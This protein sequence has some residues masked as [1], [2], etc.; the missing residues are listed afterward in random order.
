MYHFKCGWFRTSLFSNVICVFL[1][2]VFFFETSLAFSKDSVF[3]KQPDFSENYALPLGSKRD[4]IYQLNPNDFQKSVL[5]GKIHALRYPV[6]VTGLLMPKKF[7]VN[8]VNN[9][10]PG[11]G[12]AIVNPIFSLFSPWDSL[13]DIYSWLGLSRYPANSLNDLYAASDFASELASDFSSKKSTEMFLEASVQSPYYLPGRSRIDSDF[14]GA[15]EQVHHGE[16]TV[17]FSCGACHVGNLFGTPVI[18]LT[19][20]RPR[21][22]EFIEMGAKLRPLLNPA[23]SKTFGLIN[24]NEA[25]IL[26]KTFQSLRYVST[27]TPIHPTLDTSLAIVGLSLSKR[28]QDGLASRLPRHARWPRP[29]PLKFHAVDSKPAVWWNLKYKTRWLSDGSVVSGNPIF[30]NILWNEIGRGASLEELETWMEDNEEKV[31]EL[32]A[33]VFASEAPRFLDFFD[34]LDVEKAEKGRILFEA[35]C[36]SCHGGYQMAWQT[37]DKREWASADLKDLTKT[38]RVNYHEKTPVLDVGTDPNRYQGMKYF[39]E[40]LNRLKLSKKFGTIVRPQNGYVP[41]P[42]VG[43]WAR[44]PYFHNNSVSSLCEVLTPAKDRLKSYVGVMALDK[45]TDFDEDCVGYPDPS[46]LSDRKDGL[47]FTANKKG[48]LNIGHDEGI[49]T[50]DGVEKFSGSQKMQIIEFLKS[51]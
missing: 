32:T 20:R 10:F 39:S 40:D 14:L 26:K 36:S 34:E 43:I 42:L 23:I 25:K 8:A 31:N 19:N 17:T 16:K 35:N 13:D 9:D 3:S 47:K 38:L 49:I 12:G 41:P 27:K 46:L 1:F 37:V 7:M 5:E 44:W 22:F 15:T 45:D 33:G 4:N 50:E 18:G 21:A 11:V 51:L 6:T 30:T 29:N 2:G 48:L 28:A 24:E